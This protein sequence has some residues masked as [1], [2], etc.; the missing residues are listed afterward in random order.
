M[1]KSPC[2]RL[3]AALFLA[4]SG[5]AGAAAQEPPAQQSP[6]RT[7]PA[8][9]PGVP[10]GSRLT[11]PSEE[12]MRLESAA[13]AQIVLQQFSRCVVGN[14]RAMAAAFV[15]PPL[16]TD[17]SFRLALLHRGDRLMGR[18][19]GGLGGAR[20]GMPTATMMGAFAAE[21]YVR[22]FRRLPALGT[23]AVPAPADPEQRNVQVT[24]VF[25]NCIVDR[26]AAGVDALARSTVRSA[27]ERAAL[28]R[29]APL[30]A[31]CLDAGSSLVLDR[32]TL[33]VFLSEIL[34]RRALAGQ[35]AA[36][37]ASSQ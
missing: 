4:A 18:C 12:D 3:V 15:D 27:E 31:G 17:E 22:R 11:R 35:Q 1:I 28:A 20:L 33:R 2:L 25:A 21:L 32:L 16:R 8:P 29:L 6:P 7:A 23:V 14:D 5:L 13:R 34:Y 19:L 37:S 30:Y 36:A 24:R 10:I 26:D 9:Q